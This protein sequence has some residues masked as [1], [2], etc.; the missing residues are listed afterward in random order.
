MWDDDLINDEGIAL[1]RPTRTA[2]WDAPGYARGSIRGD[3]TEGLD[4]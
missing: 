2:N 4:G 3:N 1:P